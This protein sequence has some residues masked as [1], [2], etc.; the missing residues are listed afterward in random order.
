[1]RIPPA[2]SCVHC[3]LFYHQ[4]PL[5]T[6]WLH[7]FCTLPLVAADKGRVLPAPSLLRAEQSQ[8]SQ[9]LLLHPML[10]PLTI[11]V[12]LHWTRTS[13]SVFPLLGRPPLHT[14]LQ[15]WFHKYHREGDN[16]LPSASGYTLANTGLMWLTTF[17]GRT[18]WYATVNPS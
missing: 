11:L 14:F 17:T 12:A 13:M 9:P 18:H 6:A 4:A 3:C 16:H 2:V 1:M 5:R 10:Q 7:L 8:F 15:M